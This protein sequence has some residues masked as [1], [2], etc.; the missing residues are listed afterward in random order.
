MFDRLSKRLRSLATGKKNHLSIPV[1]DG[2]FKPNNLLES[3]EMLLERP[4]LEDI[5]IGASGELFAACGQEVIKVDQTGNAVS[6]CAFDDLI[7]ALAVAPDGTLAV[8]LGSKLII[9]AGTEKEL[10]VEDVARTAFVSINALAFTPSG[11]LLVTEGSRRF[12]VSQWSHDLMSKGRSGRVVR[13]DPAT[14]Q[15]DM[16]ASELAYANGAYE[17]DHGNTLVSQS[18]AHCLTRISGDGKAPLIDD[19]PGYPCRFA[20]APDGGFWLTLFCS[21]TQLVE[22]VLMEDDYRQEMMETIEPQYWISPAFGSGT[23]F[24]EPLQGGGVKQMGILKPWAPPRSYGLIVRFG[25]DL[26]PRYSLH[27]R[28]G[29]NNHGICAA[30]HHGD[31]LYVLSKGASRISTL[32]IPAIDAALDKEGSA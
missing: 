26:T 20:T 4:G 30:A 10:V 23:D 15:A 21:R 31:T 12:P 18:W 24:L 27:S 14:G 8:S 11:H 1:F 7:T 2:V 3:A 28:V 16:L 25:A 29:G 19:L 9:A 5:A 32:S 22:F 17:T 6:V 13:I